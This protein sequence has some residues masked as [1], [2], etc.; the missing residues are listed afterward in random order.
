[1]PF[2]PYDGT[3]LLDLIERLQALA[4]RPGM[5]AQDKRDLMDAA[6]MLDRYM[7]DDYGRAWEETDRQIRA[8]NARHPDSA[9]KDAIIAKRYKQGWSLTDIGQEVG[10][11]P[12]AVDER[13][14]KMGIPKRR[15]TSKK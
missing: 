14:R 1:M 2:Y 3:N 13:R 10:I 8:S 4:K 15:G 5:K 12:D 9:E 7:A 6:E 11:G